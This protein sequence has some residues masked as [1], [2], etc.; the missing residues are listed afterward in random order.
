MEGRFVWEPKKGAPSFTNWYVGMPATATPSDDCVML[1]A[2]DGKWID[3]SCSTMN[4]AI[5]ER[6]VSRKT[7]KFNLPTL[8][9]NLKIGSPSV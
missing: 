9:N 2:S 3:W 6:K 8:A 5:C 1:R 4:Y 7:G